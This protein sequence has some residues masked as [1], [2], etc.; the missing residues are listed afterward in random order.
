MNRFLWVSIIV[1]VL[2]IVAILVLVG[3]GLL[4]SSRE[5]PSQTVYLVSQQSSCTAHGSTFN[6]TLIL[7]SRTGPIK[8]SDISSVTIN[9]TNAQTSITAPPNNNVSELT[10]TAGI[11]IGGLSGGLQDVNNVPPVS[12]GAVVVHLRDGTEVS[13]T[14]PGEY[15]E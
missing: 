9:G 14:L 4:F 3:T 8:A 13:A 1:V 2:A 5:R 11:D 15:R 12:S 7:G 10:V 6:C